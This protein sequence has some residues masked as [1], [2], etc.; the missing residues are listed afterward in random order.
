MENAFLE[1]P[2]RP[3]RPIWGDRGRVTI[4]NQGREMIRGSPA[5][6]S[7]RVNLKFLK[8]EEG[9]ALPF[10]EGQGICRILLTRAKVI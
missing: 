9:R 7:L 10:E 6:L 8:R 1:N 5:F 4:S 3:V 2:R